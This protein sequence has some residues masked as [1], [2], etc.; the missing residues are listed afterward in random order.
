VDLFQGDTLLTSITQAPYTYLWNNVGQGTYSFTAK[1]TDNLGVS[2]T[3]NA[4]NVTVAARVPKLYDIHADHLGTPRMVTDASGNA[5]W[6]WRGTP[7]G[8][9]LPNQNPSNSGAQN[10]FVMNLRFPGQ[11]FDQETG[12]HYNYF[13][14]Y[15]PGTGRYVQSDPIGLLAG[16]NTFGYVEGNPVNLIDPEGLKGN[17]NIRPGGNSYNRRQWNR[18]GP[19]G[20]I[21]GAG[22]GV[23]NSEEVAGYYDDK[24]EFVCLRWVCRKNKDECRMDDIKTSNDWIPAATDPNKPPKGCYCDDRRWEPKYGPDLSWKDAAEGYKRWQQW[25]RR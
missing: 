5:V 1:A 15:D 9:S 21:K 13:R 16:V 19:R 6:E 4:S 17:N 7:F 24:G 10:D 11:V 20:P 3:S 14:D 8:E 25:K 23:N 12:L 2:S 22:E 18:H